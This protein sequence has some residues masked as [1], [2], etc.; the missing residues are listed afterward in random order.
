[1]HFWIVRQFEYFLLQFFPY[2]TVI[3]IKDSLAFLA[4]M[5][6]GG[7]LFVILFI[8]LWL[9]SNVR[10]KTL[11]SDKLLMLHI[12]EANQSRTFV[13]VPSSLL[14]VVDITLGLLLILRKGQDRVTFRQARKAKVIF[15]T[16]LLTIGLIAFFGILCFL[17]VELPPDLYTH[18]TIPKL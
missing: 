7:M 8:F 9:K 18:P 4:G 11:E 10:W 2:K 17:D 12:S 6:S 14:E 3:M 1:M 5:F 13:R 15:Y 16:V